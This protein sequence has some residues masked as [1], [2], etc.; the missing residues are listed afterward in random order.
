MT[1]ITTR[2]FSFFSLL[3]ALLFP[4]CPAMAQEK[5]AEEGDYT[6]YYGKAE[7]G[8]AHYSI[9]PAGD[10][11]LEIIT[12]STLQALVRKDQKTEFR[13]T[14][15]ALID[16]ATGKVI[17]Y[18]IKTKSPF[19]AEETA[20][21]MKAQEAVIRRVT[22]GTTVTRSLTWDTIVPIADYQNPGGGNWNIPLL[23]MTL[24][25]ESLHTK[26]DL[27][28]RCLYTGTFQPVTLVFE[29]LDNGTSTTNI[30]YSMHEETAG[31]KNFHYLELDSRDGT[32]VKM[33]SP[34]THFVYLRQKGGKVAAPPDISGAYAVPLPMDMRNC[35]EVKGRI[36]VRILQEPSSMKGLQ[37]A[38]QTIAGTFEKG[39]L[40]GTF[41]TKSLNHKALVSDP[42]PSH[43]S[44]EELKSSL[45]AEFLIESDD[46]DMKTMAD[47]L[48]R[49]AKTLKEAAA[50]LGKWVY[51]EIK[52][53]F[54]DG[55]AKATL[56]S[57]KG[58]WLPRN[59]LFIALCRSL[60]IPARL[61]GGYLLT[62]S[63][64]G[65]FIWS[66]VYMGPQSQWIPIDTALGQI[67]YFS[68]NYLTLCV[69]GVVDPFSVK[70]EI[71][72]MLHREEPRPKGTRFVVD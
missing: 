8:G 68:A 20:I 66:E 67:D 41:Q 7:A 53:D 44:G 48:T 18:S 1:H 27:S 51:E 72:I 29:Q 17:S 28:M 69:Q 36:K 11:R 62:Q 61:A 14:M 4:L 56:L 2:L 34:A 39:L 47:N 38:R 70:P 49:Q 64:A 55:S 63:T 43:F 60:G 30:R 22:S 50:L 71:E 52:F 15:K 16:D 37:R 32:I 5:A 9:K 13:Q 58:D 65:N 42:Y 6:F 31:E 46:R 25:K 3:A 35:G 12:D 45:A 40:E 21:D 54:T 19:K 10:N 23:E 26:K 33:E 59:R 24:R 57:R